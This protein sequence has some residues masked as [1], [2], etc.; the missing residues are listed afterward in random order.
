MEIGKKVKLKQ[1][2]ISGLIVDT[3]YD[4]E[5][6]QLKHLVELKDAEGDPLPRWFLEDELEL[7]K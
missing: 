3:E 7:V 5:A 2:E 4:K 1:P 6:K